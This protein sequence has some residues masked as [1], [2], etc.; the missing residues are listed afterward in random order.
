MNGVIT[1]NTFPI[2]FPDALWREKVLDFSE[3]YKKENVA[4][5]LS[6]IYQ[7]KE[8]EWIKLVGKERW[9]ALD[10]EKRDFLIKTAGAIDLGEGINIKEVYKYYE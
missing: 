1:T 6:E 7:T 5:Q 9:Y 4:E 8:Q 10:K 2:T 3:I